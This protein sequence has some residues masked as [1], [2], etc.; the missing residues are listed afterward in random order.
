MRHI[1]VALL[2]AIWFF[3]AVLVISLTSIIGIVLVFVPVI[4]LLVYGLVMLRGTGL[5]QR[6]RYPNPPEVEEQNMEDFY[7]CD[8]W[9]DSHFIRE[10]FTESDYDLVHFPKN[11]EDDLE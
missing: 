6:G 7:D 1:F 9:W 2:C 11:Q 5:L 8:H 10:D 4:V 3:S